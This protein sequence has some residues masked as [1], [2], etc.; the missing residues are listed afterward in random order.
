MKISLQRHSAL[1]L[2]VTCIFARLIL[3]SVAVIVAGAMR[4]PVTHAYPAPFMTTLA[5]SHMITATVLFNRGVTLWGTLLVNECDINN[6]PPLG[7]PL[8]WR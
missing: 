3:K 5:T 8:C 2:T 4:A 7:T 1:L 6:N